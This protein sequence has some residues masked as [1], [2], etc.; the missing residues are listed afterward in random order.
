MNAKAHKKTKAPSSQIA[1]NK[2]AGHD[3]LLSERMEA[4]L[5]LE[6]W[7][8]KSIR[9]G[10]VQMSDAFVLI[11]NGE[12]WLH[13][14]L[15]TPLSSASTHVNPEAVRTRKLLLHRNQLNQLV[16]AVERKGFS[17][18]AT[19][20]YWSRG[21]VKVEIALGKGKKLHDKRATD[22]D[23]DWKRQ[24]ERIMKNSG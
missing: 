23:R 2:K 19:K 8:V 1:Q 10:R 22:K 4:G 24:Q 18:V 7:E 9:A 5:V 16:G 20:M 11:R 21:R 14:V 13:S 3:Y 15:I 17:I 12:A 6:G